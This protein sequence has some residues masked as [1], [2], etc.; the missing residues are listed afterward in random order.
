MQKCIIGLTLSYTSY[1]I[2]YLQY[3]IEMLTKIC[4][5]IQEEVHYMYFTSGYVLHIYYTIEQA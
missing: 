4:N 1:S 3:H 2:N 5:Y